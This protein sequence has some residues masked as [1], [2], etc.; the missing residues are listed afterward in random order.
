MEIKWLKNK[1]LKG[2]MIKER[3]EGYVIAIDAVF[4]DLMV[5]E[6]REVQQ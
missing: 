2:L 5:K 6:S 4:G 1:K 3:I